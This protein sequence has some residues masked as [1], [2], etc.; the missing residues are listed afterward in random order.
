LSI[1][2]RGLV[3]RLTVAAPVLFIAAH[4]KSGSGLLALEP[5]LND[6]MITNPATGISL[7]RRC[8]KR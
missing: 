7:R 3:V 6:M 8:T 2:W 4:N 5:D 1:S